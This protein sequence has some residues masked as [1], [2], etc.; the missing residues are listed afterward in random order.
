MIQKK[1]YH[2]KLKDIR[3][4]AIDMTRRMAKTFNICAVCFTVLVV[5]VLQMPGKAH[6][7]SMTMSPYK[8]ILNVNLDKDNENLQDIQAV[9][10]QPMSCS[11]RV[12]GDHDVYL[13]IIVGGSYQRVA[14]AFDVRYCYWDDN[15][16]VSFNREDVQEQLEEVVGPVDGC[17]EDFIVQVGGE[18]FDEDGN[19]MDSIVWLECGPEEFGM[20]D[21]PL[22]GKDFIDICDPDRKPCRREGSNGQHAGSGRIRRHVDG[23]PFRGRSLPG[24][25]QLPGELAERH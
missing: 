11:G 25:F 17:E 24:V 3:K 18:G 14:K 12:T 16:L 10:R 5:A 20:Q 6:S 4:G 9:I 1:D 19:M 13:W 2:L 8:I 15:Y 23:Y 7:A 22:E 21:P